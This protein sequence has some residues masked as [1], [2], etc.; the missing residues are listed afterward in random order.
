[1]IFK[2][3]DASK[4]VEFGTML[5][6]QLAPSGA[7]ETLNSGETKPH[8][9]VSALHKTLARAGHDVRATDLNFY[10]RAKLANSFK[11][12]LMENGVERAT[13]D[14]ITQTLVL[15]LSVMVS[16]DKGDPSGTAQVDETQSDRP[17]G[18]NVKHLLAQGNKCMQQ[19]A[20][21]EAIGIFE[22]LLE[23]DPH[24]A[25]ALNNL[26]TALSKLSRYHEAEKYFRAAIKQSPDYAD[27][28]SNLGTLSRC[29]G[30][31]DD[32][33]KSLRSALKLNPSHAEARINLGTTLVL[34]NRI[35]EAK[36]YFSKA[37]KG[38]PR[39]AEALLGMG[40]IAS[41]EGRFE[42]SEKFLRRAI[43]VS[44]KM[45]AA[46]AAL[47]GLRKMTTFDEVWLR[48]VEEIVASGVPPMEA[49]ILHFAMGKYH[50]DTGQF[51]QAFGHYLDAN[52]LLKPIAGH[53]DRAARTAFVDKLMRVHSREKMLAAGKGGS[54]S[55]KPVFVVGMARS[56][57]SL[58]E[59]IIASHPMAEGAGELD[60][61]GKAVHE[62]RESILQGQIP[63]NQ[64]DTKHLAD[65]YLHTL[66]KLSS[67]ALRVVDKAPLNFDHIGT[68][69]SIFPNARIIYMQRDPIDTCL[70]CYFQN[71]SP[72]HGFAADLSDLAHYYREHH[73]LMNH[74]RTV[75]PPGS[76]LEVPYEALVADQDAWTRRILDFIELDW[77]ARCLDF[78]STDRPILTASFW[79]ARQKIFK[80][81]VGRW[82]N[83]EKFIEPLLSL[84]TMHS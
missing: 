4:A 62:R 8:T 25:V 59:Q 69:H 41:M 29:R 68:I 43:L 44:P 15:N 81:S 35:R 70:S 48:S 39:S 84:K 28:Y 40:Q 54:D 79:Q 26:G 77:D 74:W 2:W 71:L 31:F 7:S 49:A 33:E 19:G 76:I 12:R 16:A 46:W 63:M 10:K 55:K 80:T 64:A 72:V 78:Q 60:Y 1:M 27:A 58:A 61:W 65:G 57:T 45:P 32:S 18:N 11:W 47:A 22:R 83:Y 13:A 21:I 24:H 82:R 73:R 66:E 42:E 50:D 9:L 36:G 56:G 53:Y 51:A 17:L 5:A 52:E 75:L 37:L 38:R 67:T 23:I 34:L 3:L 6:D 14:E 20:D 30:Y